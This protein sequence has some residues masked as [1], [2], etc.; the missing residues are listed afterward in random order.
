MG[1]PHIAPGSA[2]RVLVIDD[3]RDALLMNQMLLRQLGHE[4]EVAST[5][6]EGVARARDFVPDI[7]LCDLTM[8]GMNGF[9]VARRLRA[10]SATAEMRLVAVSGHSVDEF[11]EL[12]QAAG[13]DEQV[14][15]PLDMSTI[16][17]LLDKA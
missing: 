10:D 4:V 7:V 12:A 6:E 15:K 1:S 11:D 3:R 2:K 5:G 14:V 16:M 13:F 8:P 9:E 17:R